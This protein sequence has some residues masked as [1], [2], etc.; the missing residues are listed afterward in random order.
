MLTAI[1]ER[2]VSDKYWEA[3]PFDLVATNELVCAQFLDYEMSEVIQWT[4]HEYDHQEI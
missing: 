2:A 1:S 3:K 4:D